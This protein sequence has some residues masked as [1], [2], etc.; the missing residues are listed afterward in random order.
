MSKEDNDGL[1]KRRIEQVSHLHWPVFTDEAAVSNFDRSRLTCFDHYCG[2][3][4]PCLCVSVRNQFVVCWGV[5]EGKGDAK[6][7]GRGV[8]CS[9]PHADDE[10]LLPRGL[11]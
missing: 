8:V 10:M 1:Q 5:D 2:V 3:S 9:A 4:N 11:S 6:L 7:S